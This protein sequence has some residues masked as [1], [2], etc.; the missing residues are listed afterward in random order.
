[1]DRLNNLAWGQKIG[2][3]NHSPKRSFGLTSPG[4]KMSVRV[5]GNVG[6]TTKCDTSTAVL[7]IWFSWNRLPVL[8][9]KREASEIDCLS[10]QI[11]HRPEI[12]SIHRRSNGRGDVA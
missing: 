1:M 12:L 9:E 3:K 10:Q 4:V 2:S 7:R 8:L 6:S 5:H 11:K